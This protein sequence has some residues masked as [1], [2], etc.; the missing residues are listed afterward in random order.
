MTNS[1]TIRISGAIS[2]DLETIKQSLGLKSTNEALE[3]L[4][5]FHS[6]PISAFAFLLE[7]REDAKEVL[8]ELRL[9]NE[10]LK[11]IIEK[12]SSL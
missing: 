1:K 8:K 9:L 11:I 5:K 4:M 7:I 3:L 12:A 6:S 2:E 10:N